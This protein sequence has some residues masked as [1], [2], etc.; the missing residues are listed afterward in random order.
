MKWIPVRPEDGD[1]GI[2]AGLNVE[3]STVNERLEQGKPTIEFRPIVGYRDMVWLIAVNPVLDMT[4]RS[5]FVSSEPDFN[6]GIK[7][8]RTVMPDI[9][10]GLEYYDDVGPLN[11]FNP[12]RRQQQQLFLA[13]DATGIKVPFNFGIGRGLNDASD[14]WTIKA[15]LEVPL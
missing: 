1:A 7:I 13:L 12:S 10:L 14:K 11:Q 3:V 2:F 5:R 6:P 8:A 15:I 9:E 4:Y